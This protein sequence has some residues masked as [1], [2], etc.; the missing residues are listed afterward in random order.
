MRHVLSWLGPMPVPRALRDEHDDAGAEV[1]LL[2]VGRDEPVAFGAYEDLI[3]RVCVPAVAGT[4]FE[5]DLREAKIGTVLASHRGERIH[6]A[7]EDLGDAPGGLP[8]LRADH[9]H[10]RMVARVGQT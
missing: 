7:G 2:V 1:V 4:R 5:M 3:G 10:A 8:H 6:V 9:P